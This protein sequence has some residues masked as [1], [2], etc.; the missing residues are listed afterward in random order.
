MSALTGVGPSI[1]S[2]NQTCNGTCALLPTA[3]AKINAPISAR[4][5]TGKPSVGSFAFNSV[6]SNVC[7]CDQSSR[8]PSIIPTSPMRVV[9]NALLPASAAL[10]LSNQ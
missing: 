9:R 4:V 10:G 6:N 7:A 3:P 2:G 1:A 8:M 5:P